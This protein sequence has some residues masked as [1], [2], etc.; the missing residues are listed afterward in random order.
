[1]LACTAVFVAVVALVQRFLPRIAAGTFDEDPGVRALGLAFAIL[2]WMVFT[3]ARFTA[4]GTRRL[5]GRLAGVTCA[6]AAAQRLAGPYAVSDADRWLPLR[7][8]AGGR[9]F[10][11]AVWLMLAAAYVYFTSPAR[12]G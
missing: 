5:L 12:R 1:M 4:T 9:A 2:A 6:V 11:G 3:T 8:V 10:V 7:E